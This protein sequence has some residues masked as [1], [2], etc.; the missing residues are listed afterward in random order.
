[1][2]DDSTT[3]LRA[4]AI[5]PAGNVSGCS[6]PLTYV[7]DSTG[8][9]P[10]LTGTAP[11]SPSQDSS[12][13]VQGSA[14]A[15]ADVE[16]YVSS[17]CTGLVAGAGS[18]IELAGAGIEIAASPN[19]TTGISAKITDAAANVSPCSTSIAYV[20][21]SIAPAAPALSGTSPPSGSNENNPRAQGSAESGSSIVV[22]GTADCSGQPLGVGTA[23][24]LAGDGIEF[25]VSDNTTTSLSALATDAA[26]NLSACSAAI[27]YAEITP[28]P[29]PPVLTPDNLACEAAKAKLAKAKDKLKKA[30]ESGKKS[31][32][33]K[34]KKKVKAARK[35]VAEACD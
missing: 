35:L 22:L 15:G 28:T 34:A 18:A 5:D 14:E 11:A 33:K 26:G 30:K 13:Q 2:D 25:S 7:E 27:T 31:K 8:I 23:G 1:V 9:A 12:P 21:D 17:N 19:A 20:H 6:A 3:V 24:E 16:I 32:I 10:T 4:K 29:S